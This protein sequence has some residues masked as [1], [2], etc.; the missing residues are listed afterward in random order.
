L[1]QAAGSRQQAAALTRHKDTTR[2]NGETEIEIRGQ[3][4]DDRRHM[5]CKLPNIEQQNTEPQ[6]DEV[7]TSIFPPAADS[8]FCGSKRR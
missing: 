5:W 2:G 4:S 6:N 7:I 1:Q 8:T 3:K